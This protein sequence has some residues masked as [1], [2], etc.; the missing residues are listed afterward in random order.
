MRTKSEKF[1][2][3]LSLWL[4]HRRFNSGVTVSFSTME[5]GNECDVTRSIDRP[6]EQ[7]LHSI[8]WSTKNT[9]NW[10]INNLNQSI[11]QLQYTSV[12]EGVL[13]A[14]TVR[15]CASYFVASATSL[16]HKWIWGTAE[17][18]VIVRYVHLYCTF[19]SHL[20]NSLWVSRMS[21]YHFN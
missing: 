13:P 15:L 7:S 1:N 16:N 18:D 2:S 11:N 10:S 9:I 3:Q 21:R 8:T 19:Y 14:T 17:A 12:H 4:F 6:I 5:A 20:W